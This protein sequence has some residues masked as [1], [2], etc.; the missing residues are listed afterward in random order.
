M[1]NLK[2]DT[3]SSWGKCAARRETDNIHNNITIIQYINGCL[4]KRDGWGSVWLRV[5]LSYSLNLMF[6]MGATTG[7][8]FGVLVSTFSSLGDLERCQKVGVKGELYRQANT[9]PNFEDGPRIGPYPR[10]N[11]C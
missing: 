8:R 9:P 5:L 10:N 3:L 2:A 6:P 11:V 7:A 4:P 1:K